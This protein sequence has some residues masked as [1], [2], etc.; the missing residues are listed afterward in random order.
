MN[1]WLKQKAKIILLAVIAIAVMIFIFIIKNNS[2]DNYASKYADFDFY[3]YIAAG[4]PSDSIRK[5][6]TYAQYLSLHSQS[7]AGAKDIVVDVFAYS[8]AEGVTKVEE[9]GGR[10]A[11]LT[12]EKGFVEYEVN[13]PSDGLYNIY[14][15]YY[16]V[17]SRGVVIERDLTLNGVTPFRGA[18][19]VRFTRVWG[20]KAEVRID[21]Q[22]N[23]LRP[24]QVEKPRW[25]SSY[26]KD[27]MGYFTEPY[28]FYLKEGSNK[29]RLT[30]VSE[31]MA[32]S[33]FEVRAAGEV[34]NYAEYMEDFDGNSFGN[35]EDGFSLKIQGETAKFR[36]SPSLYAVYDRSSGTTEPASASTIK[37]NMM[38]G[39]SWRI[40][41]QWIEWDFEVPQ[42]DL[43]RISV[44]ARQNYNRGFVSNRAVY[45]DGEL[46]C[47]EV[48]AVPFKYNNKW[49]L[50][51]LSDNKGDDLLFPLT[52]GKHTIRMEVT[53][54]E[55][56]SILNM[57][58]GS[59]YRLN[60]IYRKILVLTGP[61]PDAYRDYRIDVVYPDQV[62][63]MGYE[64]KVLYKLVDDLT[65]YTGERGPQAASALSLARQLELF[66]QKP[67]KIP[68]LLAS[69]KSKISALGDGLIALS[70]SQLD[71]DWLL[72]STADKKLP[73][74][75]ES[76]FTSAA[77]EIKSFLASFS[78]DYNSLGDTYAGEADIE[79][80]IPSGRDQSNILK[81]MIDEMFTPN[82]GIKVNLKLVGGDAIMPAVVAGIGPDVVLNVG[83]AE[84]INYAVRNAAQDLSGF[85]GFDEVKSWFAP[86]TFVPFSLN[87]S[88]YALPETQTFSLMFY[89]SDIFEDLGIN[90][91][92]TWDELIDIIPIIQ[93][94]NMNIGIPSVAGSGDFTNLFSQIYQR[95]GTLYTADN[96]KT[97]LDS[98]TAIE[99]FDYY[100]SLY[101]Q[102][103]TPVQYDFVNRFRT[104]E[105]PLGFADFSV[106][107]TLEIFAPEIRGMWK[108]G[109]MPGTMMPDG[110]I[111]RSVACGGSAVMMFKNADNSSESNTAAWEFMKWWVSADTQLRFGL[112]ME[113]VMG[114]SARYPT[115]NIEAFNRLSWSVPQM[116][117][118]NAQRQW[119][120][121]TPE[122]PGG[123]YL[124]RHITNAVRRMINDK[125]ETRET[126][127]DYTRIIND[128]ITKKRK[129]LGIE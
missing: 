101:T 68:P 14:I 7:V 33:R 122:I 32:L 24:S 80:W 48:A 28:V 71:I 15:E 13:A 34:K 85:E 60:E 19:S 116:E 5:D 58:S 44:K 4:N 27:S 111:N 55:L 21:N 72:I 96:K 126:M 118:L 121:G 83:G 62:A 9:L 75:E 53:L 1:M 109:L 70:E 51:T 49:N 100:V 69:F 110:T 77:H 125:A 36:S 88:V 78:F 43:Y 6:N 84:P 56:G 17:Q 87:D 119:T 117:T 54:G 8:D 92:D 63:A 65:Q 124:S 18:E 99:A 25:E 91:P 108:F 129:E 37:L 113:S 64:S 103:K 67:E 104:G 61:N 22:G 102:Y 107:N 74:V 94:N 79:V 30:G 26:L 106:F 20:D 66:A 50:V 10:Q 93:K 98:E 89:R 82:S 81:A 3:S 40:A 105:M 95:G 41:G 11:L 38:G 90:P 42:D 2:V 128:E 31:P 39:Q 112:E 35:N 123:Y 76:F 127:L 59:I 23:E 97:L 29:I 114:T 57:M 45:I 86:S 46:P 52:K 120:V 16:P 73:K 47:K 12:E 115:A